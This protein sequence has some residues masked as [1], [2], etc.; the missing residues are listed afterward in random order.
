MIKTLGYRYF[1]LAPDFD[2]MPLD[3]RTEPCPYCDKFFSKNYLNAHIRYVHKIIVD[4]DDQRR[5]K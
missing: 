5:N 1:W 2:T 4:I 3:K